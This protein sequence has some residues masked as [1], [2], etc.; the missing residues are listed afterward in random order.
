MQN[1]LLTRPLLVHRV[2]HPGHRVRLTAPVLVRSVSIQV[3][4]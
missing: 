4:G 3:A 1:A 2:R